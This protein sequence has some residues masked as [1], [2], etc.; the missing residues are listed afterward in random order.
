MKS[1]RA[2]ECEQATTLQVALRCR[3]LSIA[4]KSRYKELIHIENE[5]VVV[6]SDSNGMKN[7]EKRFSFDFAL[8]PEVKNLE[9]YNQVASPII[10]GVVNGLNGTIFAYGA[11]GSGKTHTMVGTANDPGLMVLSMQDIFQLV[12]NEEKDHKFEI[13]CS[14]LEVYNE[15]I[16]DLLD[17]SS[18]HLEL[19]EDPEQGIF[20]SGLKRVQVNSAAKILELL[21]I[22]NSRRKTERT[23]A[24][25]ISSRSHA[26]LEIV[27]KKYLQNETG[28]TILQGKIALVDLAG[29]ERASET[30]NVG[31]KLRDGANINKSL[32]ALAN[33]INALGKQQKRGLAY[34]P[35]RNSKL[36]R[37]LKDGLSGNSRT[38]M[39][40]TVCF[41]DHQYHHTINTLKYADRAKEIKTRVQK[42]VGSVNS[43]VANYQQMINNLQAEVCLLRKELEEKEVQLNGRATGKSK[44]DRLSWFDTL[45]CDINENVEE[46]INL[47]KALFELEDKNTHNHSELEQLDSEIAKYQ[48]DEKIG[49]VEALME[50]RKLVLDNIRDNDE[51][52]AVYRKEIEQNEAQRKGLQDSIEKAM[53]SNNNATCL[54]ILCEYRLLGMTNT[55]LQFQIAVRDQI[56]DNQ[57]EVL[58]NLWA[59]L[60]GSGLQQNQILE[61]ASKQG[62]TIEGWGIPSST[63]RKCCPSSPIAF[64][65]H[66]KCSGVGSLEFTSV[67]SQYLECTNSTICHSNPKGSAIQM[68]LNFENQGFGTSNSNKYTNIFFNSPY[69]VINRDESSLSNPFCVPI[70]VN[71]CLKENSAFERGGFSAVGN[72]STS[73]VVFHSPSGAVR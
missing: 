45:S 2:P 73:S 12:S 40:A 3:P 62:F 48:K 42:N 27:V 59:V 32:L 47:Q 13:T 65:S 44:E 39:V 21:Q 20:V 15:V 71:G 61:L 8:G 49:I 36:T 24:N 17:R 18:R 56:I 58:R 60:K 54:R 69:K 28:S 50:R 9:V 55:E 66:K 63:N 4:E 22:G 46:R 70:R 19:R 37:I 30:N 33:C 68:P 1:I 23:D 72:S 11:T 31:Q 35:Y 29:S 25:A 34:V 57:K 16:Y 51:V 41:A 53:K 38:C 26:V 14:Y 43:H 52:G 7:R 5:R 67:T 64:S 6:V 10:K